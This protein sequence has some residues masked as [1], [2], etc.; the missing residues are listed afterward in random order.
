MSLY[1]AAAFAYQNRLDQWVVDMLDKAFKI[2]SDLAS[3]IRNDRASEF[4]E[5]MI[6]QL[7]KGNKKTAASF[8]ASLLR[9]N[10]ED[11]DIYPQ[12]LRT[13]RGDLNELLAAQRAKKNAGEKNANV[14]SPNA[15]VSLSNIA[16][17]KPSNKSKKRKRSRLLQQNHW[18]T[19]LLMAMKQQRTLSFQKGKNTTYRPWNSAIPKN[20]IALTQRHKKN[21]K[22]R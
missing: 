20:V 12:A 13:I 19:F 9:R 11:T 21:S 10:Y 8:L 2:D 6:I 5:K 18:P 4:Y 1:S 17:R 14:A 15:N 22:K 3:T 7:D 16:I